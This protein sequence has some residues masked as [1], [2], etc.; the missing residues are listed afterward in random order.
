MKLRTSTR[1]SLRLWNPDEKRCWCLSGKYINT[2]EFEGLV[3]DKIKEDIL[4]EENLRELVHL[5]NEE[6]DAASQECRR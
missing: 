1:C 2:R 4:T 3:V 5:V 6:M